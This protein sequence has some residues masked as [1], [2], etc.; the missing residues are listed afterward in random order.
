MHWVKVA[1]IFTRTVRGGEEKRGE[2]IR[3]IAKQSRES[4]EEKNEGDKKKEDESYSISLAV[5]PR[6]LQRSPRLL[7]F[8][9]RR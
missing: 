3:K 8:L 9:L 6:P 7:D 1:K 5:C 4:G 2:R